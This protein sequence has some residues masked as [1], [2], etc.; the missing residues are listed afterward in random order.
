[1]KEN[2]KS[3]YGGDNKLLFNREIVVDLESQNSKSKPNR[4]K[5]DSKSQGNALRKRAVVEYE[6]VKKVSDE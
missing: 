3:E 6:E 5:I 2:N 1:M 4:K